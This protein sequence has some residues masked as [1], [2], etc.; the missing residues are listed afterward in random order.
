VEKELIICLLENEV[1]GNLLLER[2]W[3]R[4]GEVLEIEA[5]RRRAEDNEAREAVLSA[6]R[7]AKV[8]GEDMQ[9]SS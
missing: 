6:R 1:V 3:D 8:M 9:F 4:S 5:V 2:R 7:E